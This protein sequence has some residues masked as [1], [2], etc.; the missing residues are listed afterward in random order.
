MDGH[1]RDPPHR[2]LRQADARRGDWTRQARSLP[3]RLPSPTVSCSGPDH[4]HVPS[5]VPRQDPEGRPWNKAPRTWP[6][7]RHDR[8][9]SHAVAVTRLQG[10][11]N[12][13]ARVRAPSK[14]ALD[15]P[16]SP[17]PLNDEPEPATGRSS[18]YPDGTSTRRP[19]PASRTQHGGSVTRSPTAHPSPRRGRF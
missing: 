12:A 6:S 10:S 19:G 2:S 5:S 3:S 17:P 14:E 13:T 16:L 9:G 7:P 1:Q 11:L 15:T 4:A 8:L 18:A